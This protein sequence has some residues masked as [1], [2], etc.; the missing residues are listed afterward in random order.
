MAWTT[1]FRI[2]LGLLMTDHPWYEIDSP[3]Q[4]DS[5]SILVYPHRIEENLRRMITMAGNVDQLRPHVKTHKLPQIVAM[6]RRH[7]ITRFK[8]ST[9]A[10][11]EMTAATGGEDVL[12]AYPIVGP[13]IERLLNLIDAFPATKFSALVDDEETLI[14]IDDQARRRGVRVSLMLDLDIGMHRTGLGLD[15]TKVDR[16]LSFYETMIALSGV[17]ALGLHAYDG[18]LHE[19]DPSTLRSM[20]DDAFAPLWQLRDRIVAAGH[21]PPKLVLAGTPTSQHLAEIG[22]VEVGAGTTVLWDA[23][24]P[25]LSPDLDFLPAAVVVARVI[26]RPAGS[27]R[28]GSG[29]LCLDLGHK[30]VASEMPAPRV[31]WLNLPDAIEVLHSEEHLVVETPLADSIP[32]GTLLYGLPTHICPTMALHHDVGVVRQRQVEERWTVVARD[33]RIQY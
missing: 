18:H 6:K 32:V 29:R 13:N 19:A 10:E 21:E 20:V 17:H 26:S 12:L 27:D 24:Q 33:R 23:G 5:P 14:R 30:A 4:L 1:Q 28:A 16:A 22:D 15:A 9:I 31:K 25:E 11:A 2:C 7:G 3:E 8:A